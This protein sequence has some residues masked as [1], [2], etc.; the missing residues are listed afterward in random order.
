MEVAGYSAAQNLLEKHSEGD[1]GIYLCGKGN[2]AGDALV[3]ARYLVQHGISATLVF[4][5]GTDDLST[6]TRKNYELLQKITDHDPRAASVEVIAG[7]PDFPEHIA[8]DFI[9]DGMLGTG[10]STKL[11]ADY[12]DA[13]AWANQSDLLVYA[14]DIPTGLHANTG[15]VLGN[16]VQADCTFTFGMRK[17]GF[18]LGKGPAY[19]GSVVFCE[20]PFPNYL[21]RDIDNFLL[22]ESWVRAAP[23]QPSTHKYEAGILYVIAGSEGLTGAAIMTA[24]SAWA[25]GLGAVALIC[26][27]GI[28]PIFETTLP[29]IIKKPVGNRDECFF[30]ATHAESVLN[31]LHEKPGK[32]LLGP[33]LGREA[34]TIEFVSSIIRKFQ[35][36]MLID[37]DGLWCLSRLNEWRK[38]KGAEWILTPHPGELA[39]LTGKSSDSGAERLQQV[40]LFSSQ[41]DV[42]V[43]SKGFPSIVGT[44]E[45]KS[46]LT[47][48]DTRRFSRAGF[49]DVLAG[50]ISAYWLLGNNAG[51]SCALGLLNGK[52][53]T[54]TLSGS[55]PNH[56]A[57]PKDLI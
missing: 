17:L 25:E 36:D 52:Q 3:I 49:G 31:I 10:L 48:Y 53:K 11:R 20:L 24:Q 12:A 9:V 45:G 22:D 6:D 39:T 21:K 35:G 28:L 56:R 32:V 5:S 40:K 1:H 23:V 4:I 54:D 34:D 46:Y 57:E 14:V 8:A 15:E 55:N 7:W 13:V 2:N 37:A 18:Y 33:G 44:P 41:N 50:K 30:R 47:S 19:A 43:L 38:P 51:S 16:A 42:T 29:Q 26:P 27:H